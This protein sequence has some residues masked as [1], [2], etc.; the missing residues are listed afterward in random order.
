MAAHGLKFERITATNY[1]D[2]TFDTLR[3][4]PS[5]M[6]AINVWVGAIL[7]S[8]A[9]LKPSRD[10]ELTSLTD[11]C[12]YKSK[13]G[14]YWLVSKMAKRTKG[15][16]HAT[17]GGRPIP[18]I[19]A[20]GIQQLIRFG[21]RLKKIFGEQDK[22]NSKMLFYLPNI[23]NWGICKQITTQS[24]NEYLNVLCDFSA[25]PTD[26]FGR[27]WYI[28]IHE[29]RRWFLLLL[30]WAGRYDS[31]DA[32]RW[33]AGH[34]LIDHLYAYIKRELPEE[35]V[36]EL[37]SAWVID[38]L[39]NLENGASENP[40]GLIAFRDKI[41][42]DFGCES[43]AFVEERNW[44][45]HTEVLLEQDYFVEPLCILSELGEKDICFAIRARKLD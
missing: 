33:I 2:W 19:T 7:L 14:R 11:D 23:G 30:V 9:I 6:E 27:R 35:Q 36:S 42:T 3:Q 10:F 18:T 37:E 41:L 21:S 43:L 34:T 12:L 44:K 40:S 25:L 20:R 4:C 38:Q 8:I 17:N 24:L 22:H 28:R 13:D 45:R 31:L 39:A 16:E 1:G 5:V 29:M 32:A 26:A 15:T